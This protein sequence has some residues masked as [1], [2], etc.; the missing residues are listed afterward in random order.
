MNENTDKKEYKGKRISAWFSA[1]QLRAMGD[2]GLTPADVI[3]FGI[4]AAQRGHDLQVPGPEVARALRLVAQVATAL[5]DGAKLVRPEERPPESIAEIYRDVPRQD[6][7]AD[8]PAA[9]QAL[10][11]AASGRDRFQ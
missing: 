1:G 11:D 9:V 5:A 6:E 3:R 4:D 8:I 10:R 7:G 2:C